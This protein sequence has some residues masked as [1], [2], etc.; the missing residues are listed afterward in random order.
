MQGNA[1]RRKLSHNGGDGQEGKGKGKDHAYDR[2]TIPI[3][4]LSND[5]DAESILDEDNAE[6]LGEYGSRLQFLASLDE[7]GISRCAIDTALL[8]GNSS[9]IN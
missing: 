7:H 3:P 5:S 8:I 1:K 4:K 9:R 6:V 2:P